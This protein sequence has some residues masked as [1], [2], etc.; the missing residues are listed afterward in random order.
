MNFNLKDSVMFLAVAGSHAYGTNTPESD[1]D[2]RGFC[3]PPRDIR[4]GFLHRFEQA[5]A[6]SHMEPFKPAVVDYLGRPYEDKIDG[7]IYSVSKFFSLAAGANPNIIDT[8][9]ASPRDI[10]LVTTAG[11]RVWRERHRFLSKLVVHTFTG[12]AVAQLKRIEN[13]RRW[14]LNPPEKKPTR[15]DFGLAERHEVPADQLAAAM[16]AVRKQVDS[17]EIDF[18]DVERATVVYVQGQ[19]EKVLTDWGL[20]RDDRYRLAAQQLGYETNFLEMME[21]ERRYKQAMDAWDAYASWK[22]GRNDR[23]AALETKYGYDTK[24]ASHLVRL[25]QSCAEI[26]ETCDYSPKRPNAG[27]LLNIKNGGWTYEQVITYAKE[28][29]A[30]LAGLSLR[31]KLPRSPDREALNALCVEVS[32]K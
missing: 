31:S 13:H 29:E 9:F 28:A 17:W 32:S 11:W 23:R 20:A 12:Y 19:I 4:D 21:K 22:R 15:A 25:L 8:L 18:A 7:C 6:P 26:L 5:D 2:V 10:L 30:E 14:L 3:L 1:F 24:H 27:E 16:A